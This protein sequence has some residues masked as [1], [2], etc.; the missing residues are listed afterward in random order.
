MPEVAVRH[1]VEK[2]KEYDAQVLADRFGVS[3][4]A[5]R[6]RLENLGLI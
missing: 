5:L 6:F 1:F 4:T 2:E 3:L